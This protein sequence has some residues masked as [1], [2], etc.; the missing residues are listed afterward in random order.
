MGCHETF[1]EETFLRSVGCAVFLLWSWNLRGCRVGPAVTILILL[2][3]SPSK[4][5]EIQIENKSW[6]QWLGPE[7]SHAW[8]VHPWPFCLLTQFPSKFPPSLNQ[9]GSGFLSHATGMANSC[10]FPCQEYLHPPPSTGSY[11]LLFQD[12]VYAPIIYEPLLALL[13]QGELTLP[14]FSSTVHCTHLYHRT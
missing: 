14:L 7:S 1:L 3:L 2:E 8:G 13:P 10:C 9:L 4:L 6:R 5:D 11:L 12:S